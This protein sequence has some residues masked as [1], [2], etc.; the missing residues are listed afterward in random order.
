MQGAYNCKQNNG[1]LFAVSGP[2]QLRGRG[3]RLRL[4]GV[5]SAAGLTPLLRGPRG[6][7]LPTPGVL[8]PAAMP[9]GDFFRGMH[10]LKFKPSHLCSVGQSSPPGCEQAKLG[11]VLAGAVEVL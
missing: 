6:M 5:A 8:S 1:H 3:M 4:P 9:E 11:A 10:D 2:P 7:R